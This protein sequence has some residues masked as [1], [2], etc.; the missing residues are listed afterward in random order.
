MLGVFVEAESFNQIIGDWSVS[1]VQDMNSI[2]LA[3]LSFNQPI[4]DW[5]V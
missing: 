1:N 2:F 5:D 3:T 4:R